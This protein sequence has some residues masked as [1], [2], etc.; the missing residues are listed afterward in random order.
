MNIGWGIFLGLVFCGCTYLYSRFPERFNIKKVFL[1][2]LKITFLIGILIGIFYVCVLIQNWYESRPK[3]IEKID[4]IQ[5]GISYSDL[6]FLIDTLKK[7]EDSTKTY[8]EDYIEKN[9]GYYEFNNGRNTVEIIKSKVS[10]I[11]HRCDQESS[12]YTS[13]NGISCNDSSE[14]IL[15][16]FGGN[17][18]IFCAIPDTE[19]EEDIKFRLRKYKVEKYK[20]EYYL[21]LNKVVAFASFD[22]NT[23]RKSKVFKECSNN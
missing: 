7:D 20:I 13:I 18:T 10:R 5:I 21:Y 6:K 11:S 3:V 9:D 8:Q 12:D 16:K 15:T 17:I 4:N 23:V 19:S 14:E 22:Q 1:I 2:I